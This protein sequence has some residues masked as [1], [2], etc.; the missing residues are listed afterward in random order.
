MLAID[1]IVEYDIRIEYDLLIIH[2]LQFVY[3]ASVILPVYLKATL[4][5]S[6]YFLGVLVLFK[7]LSIC[8]IH[9]YLLVR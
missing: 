6:R 4:Q 5:P 9:D 1:V 7:N 3:T 8:V 2:P